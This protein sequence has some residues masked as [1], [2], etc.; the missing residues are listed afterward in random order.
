MLFDVFLCGG[1]LNIQALTVTFMCFLKYFESSYALCFQN[2]SLS[3]LAMISSE[4]I[5]CRKIKCKSS[6]DYVQQM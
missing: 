4:K 6:E 2:T 1:S 5:T 3:D